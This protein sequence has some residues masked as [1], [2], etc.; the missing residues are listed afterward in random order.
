MDL[1]CDISKCYPIFVT[2]LT[3]VVL[4]LYT[5]PPC[6]DAISVI[7]FLRHTHWRA[8]FSSFTPSFRFANVCFGLHRNFVLEDSIRNQVSA[9]LCGDTYEKWRQ[10]PTGW[11][12]IFFISRCPP[13]VGWCHVLLS[14]AFRPER[15][16]GVKENPAG[17]SRNNLSPPQCSHLPS[18]GWNLRREGKRFLLGKC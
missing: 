3:H 15:G 7:Q 5:R 17:T 12:T 6:R 10:T 11:E 14:G 1:F 18:D 16:G 13:S 9:F 4:S 2:Q 8:T